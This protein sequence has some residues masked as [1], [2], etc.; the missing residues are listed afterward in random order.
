MPQ[1]FAFAQY[2]ERAATF[3]ANQIRFVET[4]IGSPDPKNGV[5]DPGLFG[6]NSS[7][8]CIMKASDG[9]F[10]DDDANQ[11]HFL[12]SSTNRRSIWCDSVGNPMTASVRG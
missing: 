10:D 1:N 9:V 5:M 12:N 6:D 7:R 11:I 4:I 3:S 8:I 2:L